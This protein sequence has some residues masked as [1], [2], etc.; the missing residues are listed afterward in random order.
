MC[1]L[2]QLV[3]TQRDTRLAN[4]LIDIYFA[5]FDLL[6]KA[7]DVATKML[8]A[9]LTGINRAFPFADVNDEV[10]STAP[11]LVRTLSWC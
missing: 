11:V 8:S 9:L 3:L 7:C 5:L 6:T 4:F 1:F 2:N 10:P